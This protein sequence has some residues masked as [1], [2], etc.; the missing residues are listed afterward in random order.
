MTDEVGFIQEPIRHELFTITSSSQVIAQART[1]QNPRKSIIIRNVADDATKIITIHRGLGSAVAN[2]GIV[3]KQYEQYGEFTDMGLPCFQGT[4][5][6]I[7]AVASVT[8]DLAVEE[9]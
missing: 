2:T 8:S 4:I 1:Q 5:T 9:R 3:L 6:A 7:C